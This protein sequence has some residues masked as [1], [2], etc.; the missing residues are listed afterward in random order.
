M[1]WTQ[2]LTSLAGGAILVPL[3]FATTAKAHCP[4]CTAGAGGAAALASAM[5][6]GLEIIGVFI[7]SF[8]VATGL[9]TTG[10]VSKRYVPYQ[11]WAI[12]LAIFLSIIVPILPMM[13]EHIPVYLS[14]AGEYGSI[15]NRTYLVNTYLVG[16]ILG[17]LLTSISPR[18]SN[19][20]TEVRGSTVPFQ[21]MTLTF[22]L[23]GIASLVLHTLI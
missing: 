17:G 8:A 21:G 19:L 7:G 23:L 16:A 3:L 18:L 5:G 10:Y 9:W 15:L 12:A 1:R 6:V 14:I 20:I 22:G 4:L 13:T 11:D 2:R